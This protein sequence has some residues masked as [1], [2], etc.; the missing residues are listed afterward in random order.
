MEGV[1]AIVGIAAVGLTGVGPIVQVGHL[2]LQYGRLEGGDAEI[3]PWDHVLVPRSR[4]RAATVIHLESPLIDVPVVGQKDAALTGGHI[5]G[6]L[7]REA[8]HISQSP[9]S[10]AMITGAMVLG[11]VFYKS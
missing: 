1:E 4:E 3:K 5:F 2:V 6:R 10:V 11:R 8:A 9:D 7:K